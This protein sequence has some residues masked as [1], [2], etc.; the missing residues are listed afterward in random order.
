MWG[1]MGVGPAV[2]SGD[3]W[4]WGLTGWKGPWSFPLIGAGPRSHRRAI[5]RRRPGAGAGGVGLVP[6]ELGLGGASGGGRCPMAVHPTTGAGKVDKSGD[7][8]NRAQAGD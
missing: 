3:V 6:V 8:E 1:G 5:R 7:Q 2:R 4:T